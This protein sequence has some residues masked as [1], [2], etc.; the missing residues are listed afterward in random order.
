ML[1]SIA[2]MEHNGHEGKIL[3]DLIKDQSSIEKVAERVGKHRNTITNWCAQAEVETWKL[4]AIGKALRYDLSSLFQKK[5]KNHPDLKDLHYFNE[6]PT[7]YFNGLKE[8]Q[9]MVET[10][11]QSIADYELQVKMLQEKIIDMREMIEDKNLIIDS[12]NNII[13]MLQSEIEEL[14]GKAKSA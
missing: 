14:K 9:L 10:K 2:H 5:L 1:V 12:K 13:D 3:H 8:V 11:N 6:D 4:I 7:P